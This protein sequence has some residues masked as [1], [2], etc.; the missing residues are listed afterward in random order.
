LSDPLGAPA[1]LGK[2]LAVMQLIQEH[3]GVGHGG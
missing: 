3:S 1:L 2:R